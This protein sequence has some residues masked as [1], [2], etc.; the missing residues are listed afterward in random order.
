[1]TRSTLVI[2]LGNADRGDDAVG[3]HVAR[4]IRAWLPD[5]L[6]LELDDPSDALD[7]WTASDTVVV[8]DA[9]RAGGVPGTVHVLDAAAQPLPTGDWASG[10]THALGLAAVV[11]LARVLNRLP[12]RL[13][14]VGVEAGRVDHGSPL[15]DR[16][17]AAVP[18][19]ADAVI[20][21]LRRGEG[22]R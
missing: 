21:A 10:G 17:A 22:D 14:V 9:V 18:A 3:L 12:A 15:T 6:T 8:T 5:V 4:Q 1:M 7:A 19:A 13:V 2:G 11:E 20:A 16:V